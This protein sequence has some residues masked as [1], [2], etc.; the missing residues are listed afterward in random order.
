MFDSAPANWIAR[1]DRCLKNS[2]ERS[3]NIIEITWL[4]T[5]HFN[6]EGI[7]WIETHSPFVVLDSTIGP[8]FWCATHNNPAQEGLSRIEI[9]KFDSAIV[10]FALL[11]RINQF[12]PDSSSVEE[13]GLGITLPKEKLLFANAGF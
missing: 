10:C 4:L 1:F 8:R 13:D 9:A 2:C 7:R 3:Q 11:N 12:L 6:V 5:A